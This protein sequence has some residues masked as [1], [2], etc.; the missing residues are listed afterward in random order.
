MAR[1]TPGTDRVAIVSAEGD[2]SRHA[3]ESCDWVLSQEGP[4]L[5]LAVLDLTRA[6]SVDPRTAPLLVARR[7]VLAARKGAYAV[8]VAREDLRQQLRASSGGELAVFT[9][10]DEAVA[11]VKGPPPDGAPPAM[12]MRS[13]GRTAR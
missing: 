6:H 13:R 4:S 7:R 5:R 8:A 11:Y 9:S 1:Q 2:A 10:V 3:L 12:A